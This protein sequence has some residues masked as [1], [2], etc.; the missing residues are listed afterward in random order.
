[1]TSASTTSKAPPPAT[2]SAFQIAR[3]T[4]STPLLCRSPL[5]G[6]TNGKI[7][8]LDQQAVFGF[9]RLFGANRIL[10]VRAGISRTK[11]GKFSTSIG[12]TAFNIPGLP[13]NPF[14]AGG[15]PT[16]SISGGFTGFGR[17]STNP[18]FQNPALLDPKLNYTWVKGRHSF[19]IGY[20][21]E[22]LWMGVEDN[23]PLYGSFTYS[24]GY[25][26]AGGTTVADTY[27]ADF[28]FGTTSAYSVANFYE[29]HIRQTFNNAYAQ[30]DYKATS[31]LT[32]NLGLRWEYG[33]PYSDSNDNISNFDPVTQTVLSI[34]KNASN[35]NG[36]TTVVNGSGIAGK[37]LV[38]PDY[39]DFAPRVGFAYA[40]DSKTSLRGGFGMSFVHYT[41]AG[42]G[43]ILA[44]NA[45]QALFVTVNQNSILK[46]S[47]TNH[48]VGTPTVASIGTCYVSAD[49]GFPTGIVTTFNPA[50]DNITWVPKGTRDSYVESYYLALQR[51]LYKNSLLDIAYV[52]NHG[53]KLQEFVNGN[54]PN[55]SIRN[56][57]TGQFVRPYANW[58]GDITEALNEAYSHYDSVQVRFEQRFARGLTLLNSFTFSHSLDN[59]SASLE[60]NTPSA[61]D[62]YNLRG[63]YSQSDYNL[64]IANVTSAIYELPHR[65]RPPLPFVY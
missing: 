2:S 9:T 46:P 7:R 29:A 3:K 65:P 62:L 15:L 4:P 14:V 34:N 55:T 43:D 10:D 24:G 52:G 36:I 63:D 56:A 22:H 12:S 18:Q 50:T 27:F 47:A 39:T 54:Q 31:N 38:N 35:G 6:Q 20:E 13:T 32:L 5:D 19:K 51:E 53:V 40:P 1:M 25:S 30:D 42:S 8:I 59:A 41:R 64:P 60:G 58:P 49:Q 44:I 21:Y 17:Q 11:A 28:L 57:T 23:N 48:C 33:S 45:P 37:T 61:Q 26:N 16:T